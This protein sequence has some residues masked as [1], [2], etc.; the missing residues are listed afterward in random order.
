MQLVVEPSGTARCVY[1]EAIDLATLGRLEVA[2]ASHVE[3]DDDGCWGVDL[4]PVN[5]PQLGPFEHRSQALAAEAAWL[6]ANW[7]VAAQ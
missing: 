2:R 6:E 1:G 5:G 3:P 4:S 7:L